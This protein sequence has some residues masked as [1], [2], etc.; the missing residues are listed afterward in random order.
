MSIEKWRSPIF[1]KKSVAKIGVFGHLLEIAS[2]D[3]AM[4]EKN[5]IW[6]NHVVSASKKNCVFYDVIS[7]ID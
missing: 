7:D 4:I 3:F 1:E 6:Q 5:D 2:L